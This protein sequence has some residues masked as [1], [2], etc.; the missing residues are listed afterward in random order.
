MVLSVRLVL[1]S[2]GVAPFM[3][4]PQQQPNLP[5]ADS[6]APVSPPP[7]NMAIASA[8]AGGGVDLV[9]RQC[10]SH[11]YELPVHD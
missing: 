3:S 6:A 8:L 11:P 10:I 5:M 9:A 4:E 2:S 1:V 7:V